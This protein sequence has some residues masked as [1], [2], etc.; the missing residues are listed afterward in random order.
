MSEGIASDVVV[1]VEQ[2]EQL[3]Q[4]IVVGRCWRMV[5]GVTGSCLSLS[6]ATMCWM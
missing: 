4:V 6:A 2:S 3:Q 1:C 5:S